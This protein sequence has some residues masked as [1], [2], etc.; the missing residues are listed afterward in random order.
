MID[1]KING[2]DFHINASGDFVDINAELVTLINGIYR[3]F[4]KEDR[5]IFKLLFSRSARDGLMFMDKQE[6]E[7]FYEKL[8][9]D[10]EGD[11]TGDE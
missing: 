2:D 1:A 4:S 8:K 5:E 3:H 7:A 10:V 9:K 6:A 11:G